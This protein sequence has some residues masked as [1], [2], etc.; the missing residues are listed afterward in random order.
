MKE[1]EFQSAFGKWIKSNPRQARITFGDNAVFE[2]KI[3][4]GG[5]FNRNKVQ[6]HQYVGLAMA[7][8]IGLFYKI[9]DSPIFDGMKTRFTSTKPFDC[10]LIS[11]AIPWVVVFFYVKGQRLPDRECVAVNP[12][13]LIKHPTGSIKKDELIS[14]GIKFNC[15][16]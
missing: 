1:K 5:T 8:S 15:W 2:L 12:S 16:G 14:L 4:N 11:T 6:E 7:S 10:L 3:S 9:S 13:V